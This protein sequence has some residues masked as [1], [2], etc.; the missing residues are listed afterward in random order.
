MEVYGHA[1]ILQQM[2]H[3]PLEMNHHMKRAT[4]PSSHL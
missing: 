2:L 3:L 1:Q 4:V